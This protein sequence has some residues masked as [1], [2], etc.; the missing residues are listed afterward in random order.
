M[1][2]IYFNTSYEPHSWD[3]ANLYPLG[4]QYDT[5]GHVE[6]LLW[7][8]R[9]AYQDV[10]NKESWHEGEEDTSAWPERYADMG[11]REY[12]DRYGTA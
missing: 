12:L 6:A 11:A 8:E 7:L 3:L 1:R 10:R 9:D 5:E 2:K 4:V